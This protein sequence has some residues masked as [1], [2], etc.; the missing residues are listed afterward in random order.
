MLK[1]HKW[2]TYVWNNAMSLI[3]CKILILHDLTPVRMAFIRKTKNNKDMKDVKERELSYSVGGGLISSPLWKT[4]WRFFKKIFEN[5]GTTFSSHPTSI[6]LP[7]DISVRWIA[8]FYNQHLCTCVLN[9]LEI[10]T[11]RNF[12]V[13]N[14]VNYMPTIPYS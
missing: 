12:G 3:T 6:Y 7:K 1:I 2:T 14:T 4:V 11:L 10:Y 8:K 13:N 5:T 9:T